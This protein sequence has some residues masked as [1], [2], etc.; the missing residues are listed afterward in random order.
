MSEVIK[1]NEAEFDAAI[2]SDKPV[3]VDFWAEWCGPCRMIAPVLDQL[4]AELG[5]KVTI[6]KVNV[7][8]NQ[9]LAQRFGISS[10]PNLKV[11]KNGVEVDNIIG[12]APKA[13]LQAAVEK[14]I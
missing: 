2:Q 13:T 3:L 9:A 1:L 10:I 6:A 14:H 11:F 12:A 7:E 4:A 8:D 5:D